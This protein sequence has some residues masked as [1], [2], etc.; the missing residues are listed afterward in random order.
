MRVGQDSAF[1]PCLTRLA[2][3]DTR[4]DNHGITVR[5]G[6]RTAVVPGDHRRSSLKLAG[7]PQW[8]VSI[9]IYLDE[10]SPDVAQM[11]YGLGTALENILVPNFD[12]R[13]CSR[14]SGSELTK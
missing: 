9:Q 6:T 3:L 4:W 13:A 1:R 5:I 2:A 11:E 14:N 8:Y 10:I 7:L 12:I